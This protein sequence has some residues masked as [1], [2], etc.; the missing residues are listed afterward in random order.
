MCIFYLQCPRQL[1]D[2]VSTEVLSR[3][4]EPFRHSLLKV[5]SWRLVSVCYWPRHLYAVGVNRAPPVNN[6]SFLPPNVNID[7]LPDDHE[8]AR[9]SFVRW[10]S[11][12]SFISSSEPNFPIA[13]AAITLSQRELKVEISWRLFKLE[14]II[15]TDLW[16]ANYSRFFPPSHLNVFIH[17]DEEWSIRSRCWQKKKVVR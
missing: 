17:T 10:R 13:S 12:V 16:I 15:L 1:R 9:Q 3:A 2:I 6:V 4:S 7:P 14:L 11:N 8:L 5:R